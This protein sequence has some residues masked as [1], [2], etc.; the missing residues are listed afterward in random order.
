MAEEVG[1]PKAGTQVLVEFDQQY[2]HACIRL[3]LFSDPFH[4]HWIDGGIDPRA[5]K[6]RYEDFRWKAINWPIK[7]EEA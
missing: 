6:A 4:E 3:S 5:L 1:G 2:G 7:K